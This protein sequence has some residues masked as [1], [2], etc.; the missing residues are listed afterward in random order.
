MNISKKGI[1]LIH[2]FESCILKAYKDPGSKDGLPITV[3]WGSTFYT[4]GSRIKLTDIITQQHAN[5]L[6]V[7][8]IGRKSNVLTAMKLKINQNQYDSLCSLIYNIGVGAFNS[9]TLLK[10]IKVNPNDETIRAEFMKWINNDGKVLKGLIRRRKA[11]ADLYF[12]LV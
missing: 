2:S 12:S 8:E 11:E 7:C 4:D 10:K 1:S 6:F 5:D 9:S 3:G